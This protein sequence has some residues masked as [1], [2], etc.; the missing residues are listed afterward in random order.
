MPNNNKQNHLLQ[1]RT[2]IDEVDNKI[3]NLLGDRIEIIKEVGKFKKE[4]GDRFFIKSAREADMIKNLVSKANKSIPK[5]TI[6][7]IWRKIITSA[8]VLEQTIN[9]AICNPDKIVDYQYLTREYYGDFV[10]LTIHE[11]STNIIAEIE[12]GEVQI[13]IFALPSNDQK[14][15]ENWWINLANNQS[16][17][18]V[19]AKIPFIEPS[20]ED[21][22]HQLVAVA[23][24]D[25][26]PSGDDKTLLTIELDSQ[27]SRYQLENE[28]EKSGLKFKIITTVKLDQ[29]HN[30]VFYLV[31]LDGFFEEKN[32]TLIDLS[33]SEVR[34]FI[35]VL[36]HFAKP[37]K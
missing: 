31:E 22:P 29:V 10:P 6:V 32:Q 16:G 35:K 30:I 7:N 20:N 34:P 14:K 13:G 37:I 15:T 24:K 27:F 18:R 33:K 36:G 21:A 5:S 25:P 28:L 23:I 3:I 12:S 9:V 8:N 1:L 19:F 11:S 4:V 26:E 2:K 17:I